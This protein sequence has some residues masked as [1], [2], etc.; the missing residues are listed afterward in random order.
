VPS[1]SIA[2][3]PLL[4]ASQQPVPPLR[5]LLERRL[6][7]GDEEWKAI[8]SG[9]PLVRL[10]PGS[11][12]SETRLLGV[13]KIQGS[14]EEFVE[15]YRDIVAFEKGA[16]VLQ[17]GRF[18]EPPQ[19]A[20][21][22]SLTI[23]ADDI[24]DLEK[25]RPGDCAIKLSADGMDAFRE[26]D[27][28]DAAAAEKANQL[29]RQMLVDFLEGYRSGGNQALGVLHDKK[30]PLLVGEQFEQL[31]EDPDLP[32]YFPQFF[33][34]LLDYPASALPGSEEIFYWSKVDF[35]LKTVI[36]LNHV[37]IYRPE[38]AGQVKYAIASKM[39]YTTHYFNTGIETKFLAQD[40]DSGNSY[41]LVVANRSRSDGLTGLTGAI[42]G[43]K[44][45]G[46][47]REGLEKY[48]RSVKSSMESTAPSFGAAPPIRP[49][50]FG[51]PPESLR[52][53]GRK[54][55]GLFPWSGTLPPPART[56]R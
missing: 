4:L 36:R 49:A 9:E 24:R 26:I 37:L 21:L 14:P 12:D 51:R 11:V 29:A 44:V 1:I 2:I 25:C 50:S 5:E 15:R 56:P 31:I 13:V 46:E 10:R 23:D 33:R 34:F 8:E 35:G 48:L 52:G 38:T 3:L 27:W 41:Y 54:S 7:I 47:A 28:D 40:P 55:T 17:I 39:L 16:G 20:D 19:L 18:S 43:G 30:K 32:V 22:A 45:R 53:L 42:V 6:E